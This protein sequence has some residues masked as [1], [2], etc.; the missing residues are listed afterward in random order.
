M[1][2]RRIERIKN[3]SDVNTIPV[4]PTVDWCEPAPPPTNFSKWFSRRYRWLKAIKAIKDNKGVQSGQSK[5]DQGSQQDQQNQNRGQAGQDKSER[6][7]QNPQ[8]GDQGNQGSS[9]Q[10]GARAVAKLVRVQVAV[11]PTSRTTTKRA[12]KDG[13][14]PG[15]A[16][17]AKAASVQGDR[18]QSLNAC[19][20]VP[21]FRRT[22]CH[23]VRERDAPC[24]R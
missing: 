4:P 22:T 19:R 9:Q 13:Q 8:H 24:A 11:S 18:R 3:L 10:S 20:S 12:G 7:G 1:V 14:R 5:Q 23:A 16:S 15:K 17:L 6:P 2:S 21:I